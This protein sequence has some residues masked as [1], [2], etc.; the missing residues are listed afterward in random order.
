MRGFPFKHLPAEGAPGSRCTLPRSQIPP[1]S[2]A[3]GPASRP[4]I[5]PRFPPFPATLRRQDSRLAASAANNAGDPAHGRL[6]GPWPGLDRGG[7]TRR[8]RDPP[9]SDTHF[10]RRRGGTG[11]TG[12]AVMEAVGGPDAGRPGPEPRAA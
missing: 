10:R 6:L 4:P 7:Q 12:R 5:Y 2:A 1:P 8:R 9:P 11:G 3:S